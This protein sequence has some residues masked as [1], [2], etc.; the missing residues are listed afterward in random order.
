MV[1]ACR[2]LLCFAAYDRKPQRIHCVFRDRWK[3]RKEPWSLLQHNV[4]TVAFYFAFLLILHRQWCLMYAFIG[5]VDLMLCRTDIYSMCC[6]YHAFPYTW[7]AH[8]WIQYEWCLNPTIP[9]VSMVWCWIYVILI[10]Q[11]NPL[12]NIGCVLN[13]L[14]EWTRT[15][16]KKQIF[17]GLNISTHT[18]HCI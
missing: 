17:V 1:R 10:N 2:V 3:C 14:S 16:N 11:S 15:V 13:G 4:S 9:N 5:S 18:I 12:L 6:D 8:I 7:E